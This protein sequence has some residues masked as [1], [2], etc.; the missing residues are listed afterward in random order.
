MEMIIAVLWNNY[1]FNKL[2]RYRNHG[3]H[4]M[5]PGKYFPRVDWKLKKA[6]S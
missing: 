1:D 2:S 6:G 4:A 5:L 3:L